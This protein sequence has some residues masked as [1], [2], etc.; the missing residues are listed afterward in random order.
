[1]T[2]T[3][4]VHGMDSRF[5]SVCN[6]SGRRA[7]DPVIEASLADIQRFLNEAMGVE[8]P[9]F[10]FYFAIRP[11]LRFRGCAVRLD[12]NSSQPYS[13]VSRLG[14]CTDQVGAYGTSDAHGWPLS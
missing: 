10:C 12:I 7:S 8:G 2:E 1:M 14:E 3:R 13:V 9:L 4:C 11:T 5:C 6:R